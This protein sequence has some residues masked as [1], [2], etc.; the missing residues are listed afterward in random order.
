MIESESGVESAG[1]IARSMASTEWWWVH[2][3]WPRTWGAFGE[4]VTLR[5]QRDGRRSDRVVATGHPGQGGLAARTR[6]PRSRKPG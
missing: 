1:A 2:T 6:W 5:W 4:A 3:I